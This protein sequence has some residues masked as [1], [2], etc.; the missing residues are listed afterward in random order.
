MEEESEKEDAS[1]EME[2]EF[3][4]GKERVKREKKKKTHIAMI[5]NEVE[6]RW[7][8]GVSYRERMSVYEWNQKDD[9][10]NE[11]GKPTGN[12]NGRDER[13]KREEW[14]K[15]FEEGIGSTPADWVKR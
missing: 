4:S 11:S 2:V 12:K 8:W 15:I 7:G 5:S 13:N 6:D 14:D 10:W 9:E 1:G 3:L